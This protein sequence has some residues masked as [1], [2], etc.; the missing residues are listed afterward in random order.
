MGFV[1]G[2]SRP[3][4]RDVNFTVGHASACGGLH[5]A[6]RSVYVIRQKK[7][8]NPPQIEIC[9]TVPYRYFPEIPFQRT[10]SGSAKAVIPRHMLTLVPATS[11][12]FTGTSIDL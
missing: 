11:F 4:V 6:C 8:S 1:G 10:F 9:P 2:F 5:S 3:R 12:H 7:G